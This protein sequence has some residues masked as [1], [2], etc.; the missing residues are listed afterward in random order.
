MT[1]NQTALALGLTG[2]LVGLAVISCGVYMALRRDRLRSDAFARRLGM[3]RAP[4]SYWAQCVAVGAFFASGG[5]MAL[6]ADPD[7]VLGEVGSWK[8]AAKIGL[9][10]VAVVAIFA[11]IILQARDS[12]EKTVDDEDEA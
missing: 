1:E 10:A 7:E 3:D 12:K 6:L 11:V 2:S 4:R 8:A 5:L 9:L